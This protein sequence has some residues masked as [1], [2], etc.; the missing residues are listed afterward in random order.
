M[1]IRGPPGYNKIVHTD[2]ALHN[3]QTEK[4]LFS[5]LCHEKERKKNPTTYI[6]IYLFIQIVRSSRVH[7]IK[8]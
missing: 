1:Y 4:M 6:F 7:L 3:K 2:S 8:Q 5:V